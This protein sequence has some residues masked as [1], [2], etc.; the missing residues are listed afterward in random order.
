VTN[1]SWNLV[2]PQVI[3]VRESEYESFVRSKVKKTSVEETRN[4]DQWWL[5]LG[6]I[7]GNQGQGVW[8]WVQMEL[9]GQNNIDFSNS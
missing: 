3:K 6:R 7:L 8:I 5:E 2:G 9:K 4:T 1:D